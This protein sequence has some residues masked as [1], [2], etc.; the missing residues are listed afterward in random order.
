MLGT[1]TVVAKSFI[2]NHERTRMDT[3]NASPPLA[4]VL[5]FFVDMTSWI[6]ENLDGLRRLGGFHPL[7]GRFSSRKNKK[8]IN[9]CAED[10]R[11]HLELL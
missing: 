2:L 11:L 8:M 5:M 1:A 3:K 9:S 10:G 6:A 4:V 7:R